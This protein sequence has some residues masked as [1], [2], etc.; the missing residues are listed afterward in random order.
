M[1][2]AVVAGAVLGLVHVGVS[3]HLVGD[4][5]LAGHL[6]LVLLRHLVA[7][8]LHVLL[9]LRPGAVAPVPGLGLGLPLAVVTTVT[10]ADHMAVV[11]NNS[12]A[13]V[14]L[15]VG[16]LAVLG[17]DVLA[18]LDVGRVHHHVVL[19]V[20]LLP[21]VLLRH[22]VALLLH[23][24]LAVRPGAVAPVPRLSLGLR[25]GNWAGQHWKYTIHIF[26]VYCK[27]S[28]VNVEMLTDQRQREG[29]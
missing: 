29:E 17:H 18:L 11:T 24:L 15:G 9:A 4:T 21:V 27:K 26:N 19:L 8:L 25:L 14:H 6:A 12:G 2:V 13:V 3:A 5:H 1:V 16:L 7:L 20:T 22:L 28:M 10:V 23:V